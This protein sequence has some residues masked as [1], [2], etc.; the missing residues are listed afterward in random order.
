MKTSLLWQEK[1]LIMQF[2]TKKKLKFADYSP[3]DIEQKDF[4]LLLE[5]LKKN[6]KIFSTKTSE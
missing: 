5:F 3:Q 2:R 1:L 6:V 4:N